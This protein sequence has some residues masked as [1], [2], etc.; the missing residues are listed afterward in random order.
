MFGV[1]PKS[2]AKADYSVCEGIGVVY[3]KLSHLFDVYITKIY[4]SK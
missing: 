2:L 3:S 4:L 1:A